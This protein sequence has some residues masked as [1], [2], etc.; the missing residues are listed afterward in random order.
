[1][2]AVF[3]A[4]IVA[5]AGLIG[6]VV[7][8]HFNNKQRKEELVETYR[9]QDQV[10]NQAKEAAKLLLEANEKVAERAEVTNSKLDVIHTLVNSNMTA[11]MQAEL[12]A[13]TRELAMMK[14][15]V[16]LNKVMGHEPSKEA[17]SAIDTTLRR[18]DELRVN[19]E[20]RYKQSKIVELQIMGRVADAK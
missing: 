19:M 14:E 1:M 9:R 15:V 5:I 16:R 8:S 10:A 2:E 7:L 4:L 17:L 20:D 13:T 6:P 3:V 12:D 11:A 18:I